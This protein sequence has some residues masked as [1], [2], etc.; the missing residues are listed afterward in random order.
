MKILLRSYP[1]PPHDVND[2]SKVEEIARSM[3][4][5]G[6]IG[7]PIVVDKRQAITGTHRISAAKKVKLNKIPQIDIRELFKKEGLDYDKLMKE[8]QI[9]EPFDAGYQYVFEP[10]SNKTMEEYGIQVG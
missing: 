5:H 6:W 8:E 3:K 9:K 1:K 10:L 4:E 7:P 2:T